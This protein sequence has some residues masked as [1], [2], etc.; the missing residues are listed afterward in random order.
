MSSHTYICFADFVAGGRNLRMPT[1]KHARSAFAP[2]S[3]FLGMLEER[4]IS[5]QC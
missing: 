5:K 3:V 2:E 1:A 4:K